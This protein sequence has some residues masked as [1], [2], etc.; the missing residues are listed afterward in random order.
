MF[1]YDFSCLMDCPLDGEGHHPG[2]GGGADGQRR[3]D[4]RR[5]EQG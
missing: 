4:G 2:G 1:F 3:Q 5:G